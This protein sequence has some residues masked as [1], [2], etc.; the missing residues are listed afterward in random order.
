MR[1][2][3][4]VRPALGRVALALMLCCLTAGSALART[5]QLSNAKNR[6]AAAIK[7]AG[8]GGTVILRGV[9]Y[10]EQSVEIPHRVFLRGITDG[11]QMPTLVIQ[12]TDRLNGI[13]VLGDDVQLA[14]LN[15][16]PS[17]EALGNV[18]TALFVI[19]SGFRMTGNRVS[20]W[21]V[22]VFLSGVGSAELAGNTFIGSPLNRDPDYLGAAIYSQFSVGRV[23]ATSNTI[24]QFYVG[25]Y[26][27]DSIGHELNLNRLDKNAI[28]LWMDGAFQGRLQNND[29]AGSGQVGIL[30]TEGAAKLEVRSNQVRGSSGDSIAAEAG[31]SGN[32]IA[33][34]M[35][36]KPVKNFGDN[37]VEE[38]TVR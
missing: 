26:V 36:D 27:Q 21:R 11:G 3:R 29:V 19:G 28:G 32:V 15:L 16:Q 5:V 13:V 34:N 31:T 25:A 23:R 8:P 7:E 20:G 4:A 2:T 10:E 33:R 38:N 6:L 37:T 18:G 1:W 30:L 14:N 12:P 24:S 17:S 22:G 9:I 35:V